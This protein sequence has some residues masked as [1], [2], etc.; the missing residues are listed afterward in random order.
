MELVRLERASSLLH[1]VRSAI[2]RIDKETFGLCL[3]C[4]QEISPKRLAAVPWATFCITCQDAA[5]NEIEHP[6]DSIGYP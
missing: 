5:D 1:D 3:N 2:R 6:H 4:E